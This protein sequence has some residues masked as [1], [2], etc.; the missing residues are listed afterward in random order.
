MNTATPAG[1]PQPSGQLP[2]KLAGI[3]LLVGALV[4]ALGIYFY[5]WPGSTLL[6]VLVLG[7]L[8]YAIGMKIEER[9]AAGQT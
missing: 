9:R 3:T 8:A 7:F 4:D 1:S 2:S 6:L 5:N